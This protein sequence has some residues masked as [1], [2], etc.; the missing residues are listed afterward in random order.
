[1]HILNKASKE[2]INQINKLV[3]DKDPTSSQKERMS[4]DTPWFNIDDVYSLISPPP[5]NTSQITMNEL[6]HLEK[7]T[8]VLSD[9]DVALIKMADHHMYDMFENF[10]KENGL[11]YK[12]GPI[13]TLVDQVDTVML[14]LKYHFN[15]PRPKQMKEL[16]G[17]KVNVYA[18]ST[19]N[20]PAYPSGHTCQASI[21]AHALS[22]KHPEYKEDFFKLAFDISKSRE[23]MG[24]HYPTDNAASMLLCEKLYLSI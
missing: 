13:K 12:D 16:T 14:K 2:Q 24:V 9:E 4:L 22:D 7:M 23:L 11:E 3:Y 10:C 21:I 1:M 17:H 8:S 6:A 20:T 5:E 19:T 18:T 15:R